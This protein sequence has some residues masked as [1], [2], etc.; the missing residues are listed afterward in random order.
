M[1]V[2]FLLFQQLWVNSTE[3]QLSKMGLPNQL[4]LEGKE[5]RFGPAIS[6]F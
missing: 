5:V 4:E 1:T 3:T 6:G 2:G